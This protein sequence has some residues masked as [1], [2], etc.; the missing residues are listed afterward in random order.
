VSICSKK[1]KDQFNLV[2]F[3]ISEYTYSEKEED[4]DG[5]DNE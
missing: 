5:I 3:E 4:N 1:F 2:K